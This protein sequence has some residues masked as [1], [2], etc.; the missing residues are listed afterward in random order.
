MAAASRGA[1]KMIETS[2]VETQAAR[3]QLLA[4]LLAELT[5][6]RRLGRQPDLGR[7][8]AQHPRVAQELRELWAVVQ[9]AQNVAQPATP[10]VPTIHLRATS[11]GGAGPDS[12]SGLALPRK[13]GD[14]ELQEELGRGGMGVV[15]KARQKVP[16]RTVALK[17]IL[18]ADLASAVDLARF[19]IESQAAAQLD[20]PNIVP[21]YEVG[22][23]SGQAYFSMKYVP[24]TTLASRLSKGPLSAREAAQCLTTIC[25]AVHYAHKRGILHRDLKPSNVLLDDQGQPYVT[26][27]GLAKRVEGGTSL[28]PS[29]AI[30]GTPSYMAPEQADSSRGMLSRASDVY[31]LGAILY[32]ILTGRPPYQ[33]APYLHP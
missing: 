12:A 8:A 18:R 30:V 2:S 23:C 21:V 29:R 32:E 22:D 17:M 19:R 16:E 13:F 4:Q 27:F 28:T 5:E 15:Y 20:H 6:E 3:E 33:P 25:R 9:L 14:Y 24:G 7:V 1:N 10:P 26:D 11:P 31:S